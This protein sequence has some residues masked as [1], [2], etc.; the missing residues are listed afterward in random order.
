MVLKELRRRWDFGTARRKFHSRIWTGRIGDGRVTLLAPQTFM[1]RSGQAVAQATSFTQAPRSDV[2]VI[3]DDM[4]LPV[5]KLR[6]RA[7]G[8]AGGHNGLN[9]VMTALGGDD[10][11][12][13]RVGIGQPP[14]HMD[15][16]DYVLTRFGKDEEQV[17]LDAVLRAADAVEEW[18]RNGI[19]CVMDHYN[20]ADRKNSS[21]DSE[22]KV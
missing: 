5:G 1:N 19:T 16:V 3:M 12:R 21:K 18:V 7:K 13:L 10:V 6:A 15:A 2:L 4:A 20:A 8:S 22:D 9:D 11:P 14:E 17:I